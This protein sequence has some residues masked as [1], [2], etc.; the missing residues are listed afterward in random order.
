MTKYN[1]SIRNALFAGTMLMTVAVPALA[2]DVTPQ[3]LL[4]PDREPQNW[5]MNHRTYDGQRFSPLARINKDNVKNL[6]L[7]YAVPL[8]GVAGKEFIEATPLA[9]DG[10]LYITDSWGVLYKIDG[11]SGD[12]GRIVWRMDPKSERQTANRGAALFGNLVISPASRP[13]RII[14]TNKDTGQVVWETNVSD[15]NAGITVTGAPLPIKDKIMF[16]ASG[17]DGGVRDFVAALDA[18]TGRLLWRKYT[19]PAP[20]E[21]GSET[22]KDKNNAWQTGGGAVWVTG[23]YDPDTNQSLWGVGNP[24]P[25]M[26][27]RARPGDNLYTNSVISWD[28]D[29]GKMNWYF[30]FTPGDMWDFDEVGTHI[31]IERVINGQPR[32]LVTHSA[33]NGFLYTMERA[34]GAMVGAKPYMEVNWTRGIDQKTGK[35][36]DYDPNKDV[37]TYSGVSDPT[38]EAPVKKV[39]PNRTGG[40]NYFPS[41]YSPKTQL[42]YIPAMTACEFVTNNSDLVKREPGWYTRTGGG[43]KVDSRYESNLTAVDPVTQEIKKNLHLPYPNYSGV[44][45][46]AGG[47]V[48]VGLLDGS[49]AAYDDTTLDELWKVNVGSGFSAP[50]MTFEVG[51]KQYIAIASGPSGAAQTKLILTPELKE[52]RNATVLYV[53]GM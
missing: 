13:A 38:A 18:A 19:I 7:A 3:R 1:H 21:P 2:A 34:S 45:S 49:V 31:L 53:F 20:G 39:C 46:T 12:A 22:W 44:L 11:T 27:A 16:G 14:A 25:M 36:V 52:Q 4:N 47:L 32:K 8:A 40:N 15:G 35:P 17:G 26:D 23:T 33:R 48:F 41:S 28:P 30:Q 24:V 43:Y 51:G 9:E 29:N 50:P 42:L 10:F 37:Q 6:R 5:L